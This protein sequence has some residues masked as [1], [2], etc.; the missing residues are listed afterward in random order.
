MKDL[1]STQN[2][3]SQ[4]KEKIDQS[5]AKTILYAT[6]GDHLGRDFTINGTSIYY[7]NNTLQYYM[8]KNYYSL[9]GVFD[10]RCV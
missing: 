1:E 8:N 5:G 4:L 7:D 9:S 6:Q 3:I 2:A 10:C